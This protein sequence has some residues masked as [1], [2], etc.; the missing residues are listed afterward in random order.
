MTILQMRLKISL[1][2]TRW[3][4]AK[5]EFKHQDRD[6]HS[7]YMIFDIHYGIIQVGENQS[8][9]VTVNFGRWTISYSQV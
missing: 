7:L 8:E 5:L 9:L 3:Y 6:C 2:I 4:M 1:K